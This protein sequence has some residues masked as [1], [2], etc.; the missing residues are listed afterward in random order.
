MSGLTPKIGDAVRTRMESLGL[1]NPQESTM[2]SPDD[3]ELRLKCLS[4]AA[5]DP[6]QAVR[7][8]RDFYAF[9]TGESDLSARD[10]V[11]AA[12]DAAGVK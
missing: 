7:L 4:L 11:N 3:Q 6:Y 12:L 5:G 1:F 8:A 9:V 10:K 2:N